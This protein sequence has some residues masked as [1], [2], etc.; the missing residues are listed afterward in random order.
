MEQ[1]LFLCPLRR[2]NSMIYFLSLEDISIYNGERET[3]FYGI[4]KDAIST[5]KFLDGKLHTKVF[6]KSDNLE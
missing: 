4:L 6:T 1:M 2:R 5:L 3:V